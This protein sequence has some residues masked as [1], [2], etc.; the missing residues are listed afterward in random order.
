LLEL[1][2]TQILFPLSP[3]DARSWFK[4]YMLDYRELQK[5][6]SDLTPAEKEA[7]AEEAEDER[8]EYTQKLE[9]EPPWGGNLKLNANIIYHYDNVDDSNLTI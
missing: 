2:K 6:I 5:K 4:N 1:A 8:A 7:H 9:L 3:A